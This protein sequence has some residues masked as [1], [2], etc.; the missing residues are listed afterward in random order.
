[1]HEITNKY[2][3]L[4]IYNKDKIELYHRMPSYK[5][6]ATKQMSG[7]KGDKTRI[8]L[9]MC[10][11]ANGLDI[12]QPLCLGHALQSQCFKKKDGTDL[13]FEYAYNM[14]AWMI[15]SVFQKWLDDFN[16]DMRRQV[17]HIALLV[18][19]A[20]SHIFDP[21]KTV[22][23]YSLLSWTKYDISYSTNGCWDHQDLWS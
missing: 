9:A 2:A 19:N 7:T 3:T 14:K 21:K 16:Q 23:H 8:T 6:L 4:D 15:G 20:P 17:R 12:I 18:D 22:P 10:A 1:M 11:N 5:T 13:G